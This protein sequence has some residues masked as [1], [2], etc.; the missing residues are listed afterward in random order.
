MH[1]QP[2]RIAIQLSNDL[3][4]LL[5]PR[6]KRR[7]VTI[8]T[9]IEYR[10]GGYFVLAVNINT[11]DW[12]RL[13]RTSNRDLRSRKAKW[14]RDG[15]HEDEEEERS[16]RWHVVVVLAAFF[17]RLL[18]LSRYDVVDQVLS[19][20]YRFHWIIYLPLCKLA[21]RSPGIGSAIREFIISS[22]IDEICYYV[23]E[24]G[25]YGARHTERIP[26]HSVLVGARIL[27]HRPCR[28]AITGMEM[29]ISVRRA[30]NQAS[31]MLSALRE[32]RADGR[33][34][35]K[36]RQESEAQDIGA[37]LGPLLGPA[38]KADKGPA[39]EPP[40]FEVP[41]N[42]EYVGLELDIPV[43]FRRLRW[44]YLSRKSSF[45]TEALWK[46]ESKYENIT[47][48]DWSKHSDLIGDP[49]PPPTVNTE[50][51]VGAE[52]EAS[53]LMPKSAFVSANMSYATSQLIAYNDYCFCVKTRCTYAIS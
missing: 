33:E 29:E 15:R 25:M 47:I 11:I 20:L 10:V 9:E 39:V 21:Y 22:A 14:K 4:R 50:D 31:F 52:F 42:L 40:G 36:R 26:V 23:N 30:E 18:S 27:P 43:G 1:P 8:G 32:I 34:L 5:T 44:A 28:G 51:F 17:R 3:Y 24:K 16:G 13:V 49:N 19:F 37:I 2:R 6:L 45:V 35:Q 53:Y 7:G 41:P 12:A 46:T 38:I 48:G